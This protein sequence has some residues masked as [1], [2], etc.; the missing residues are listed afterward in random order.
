MRPESGRRRGDRRHALD[1]RKRILVRCRHPV[2]QNLPAPRRWARGERE[3]RARPSR[4]ADARQKVRNYINMCR[5]RAR[6]GSWVAESRV[7]RVSSRAGTQP[8]KLALRAQAKDRTRTQ[9]EPE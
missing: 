8:I 7:T 3:C 4:V 1:E 9:G 2:L 5:A 6:V